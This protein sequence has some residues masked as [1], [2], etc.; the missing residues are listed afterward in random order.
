LRIDALQL[1]ARL[2][3]ASAFGAERERRLRTAAK[4]A[5]QIA[6]ENMSY[7]NPISWMIRAGIARQRGN[8]AQAVNLL[9]KALTEFESADMRLYAIATRRRLG[10]MVGGDRGRELITQ[11]E[12]WMIKQQVKDPGKIM[13]LLAP[14]FS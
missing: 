9:E 4:L 14:G 13:N 12:D 10:E 5:D 1:R 3:L 7:S 6:R 11:T 2:A 8:E